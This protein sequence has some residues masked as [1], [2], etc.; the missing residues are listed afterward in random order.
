ML[1]ETPGAHRP[2]LAYV[3]APL[4]TTNNEWVM[5]IGYVN[6]AFPMW[7]ILFTVATV[8]VAIIVAALYLVVQVQNMSYEVIKK[9]YMEDLAQPAKLRLRRFLEEDSNA[10]ST[11]GTNNGISS[12]PIADIFP[13]TTVMMCDLVGF[14]GWSSQREPSQVFTLLQTIFQAFDKLAKKRG[15]F[16]GKST[17]LYC[18]IC[19]GRKTNSHPFLSLVETVGDCYGEFCSA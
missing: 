17:L 7:M 19:H 12:A 6:K 4:E 8:G 1:A 11:K 5:S 9:K 18:A 2:G 13:H 15:V 16:K 3:A 14:V 10:K